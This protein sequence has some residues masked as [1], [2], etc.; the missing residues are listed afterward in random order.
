MALFSDG[1][2]FFR[3]ALFLGLVLHGSLLLVT[4]DQ[5]YDA[6]VHIFFADHYAQSWFDLWEYRWYTG[7]SVVSYPPL[8]HQSI[9]LISKLIGLKMAYYCFGLMA[10]GLFI[11][12][13]Y[14]FSRIWVDS[15]S[16]G[17]A[18]ILA[19]LSPAFVEALHI[20]GQLPSITGSSL[21]LNAC[22]LIYM[23]VKENK[24]LYLGLSLLL[25]AIVTSAHHVTT[26]FGT[27]FFV[28]PVMGTA[29]IDRINDKNEI[30]NFKSF[31]QEVKE[32]L[33]RIIGFGIATIFIVLLV[34]FPYW[35]W[36][37]TDPISQIPIPHGSRNDFTQNL[38]SGLIF[39]FIPWGMML[40]VFP[41]FLKKLFSKRLIFLCISFLLATLLGTGGTTSIPRMLLGD[42]AFDI[43]TFDRFTYWASLMA[44]PFWGLFVKQ[45]IEDKWKEKI[46]SSWYNWFYKIFKPAYL[47]S[48]FIF[49][50]FITNLGQFRPLQPNSIDVV[51]IVNFMDRDGHDK[52]RYLTLGFGDQM[53]WLSANSKALT[54]DGN[55]HS[56]RRLPEFTSRSVERLENAKYRG[57]PGIGALQQFLTQPNKYNLKFIFSNDKFYEPILHFT[58]W[59]RIQQLE[60][61]IVVWENPE[62]KPLTKIL[63]RKETP[64]YQRY[65]WG[66][67]PLLNL[68][69]FICFYI[70]TRIKGNR[71]FQNIRSEEKE[72]VAYHIGGKK[73]SLFFIGWIIGLSLFFI[74][75]IRHQY[76]ENISL[77]K[78]ENSI[79]AYYNAIDFKTFTKAYELLDPMTKPSMEQFMLEL[80]LED[81]ILSSYAKLDAIEI[82]KL[83]EIESD[84][85]RYQVHSKWISSL[86]EYNHQTDLELIKRNGKYYILHVP[87]EKTTPVDQFYVLPELTFK[88][89]GRRKAEAGK[90][91]RADELDRPEIKLRNTKLISLDSQY[92]I[93]GEIINLDNDPAYVNVQATIYDEND[94][95]L[96]QANIK[97][98]IKRTLLPKEF[99][100]FKIDLL[101]FFTEKALK[102]GL[103]EGEADFFDAGYYLDQNISINLFASSLVSEA[104]IYRYAG[105]QNFNI[106]QNQ[107]T[108]DLFN[109]GP[110]EISVPQ[111]ISA[112]YLEDNLNWVDLEYLDKGIRANRKKAFSQ[113]LP[114]LNNIKLIQNI[115][116]NALYTNGTVQV[117]TFDKSLSNGSNFV[118]NDTISIKLMI[119]PFITLTG[120]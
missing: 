71:V 100:P 41:F 22:P 30:L 2:D 106:Q 17:Y 108:A 49:V 29:V 40:W 65:M 103:I 39:F 48:I 21:L 115:D 42:H 44:L 28:L 46:N 110:Q 91:F 78:A 11:R 70:I 14:Y 5:T 97:D 35:Y 73:E 81:G 1:K 18:A 9:A 45:L 116:E 8:V 16:A 84:V 55:Y 112:F 76:K 83:E 10:T 87:Y 107:I 3:L 99:S 68:F 6:F 77:T 12:G 19:A 67:L 94:Q 85:E 105:I 25:L 89:Q 69:I 118:L 101:P 96:L 54:V 38:S 47:I 50:I 79:R 80:S 111:I 20:F 34:V 56:A 23:W 4:F 92:Y 75:F 93:I 15:K 51:P 36:S 114:F 88:N 95:V 33:P 90:T 32:N 117:S 52:W 63:P 66:I 43:L 104:P 60:N 61:N 120:R 62:V 58:G 37:K 59:N 13:V 102:E 64:D 53:A 31:F 109:Y 24:R 57:V 72:I 82:N 27:V 26:I 86:D 113:N 74:F 119:N 7:F 98:A